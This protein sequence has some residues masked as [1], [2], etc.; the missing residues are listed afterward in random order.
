MTIDALSLKPN[1]LRFFTYNNGNKNIN[2]FVIKIDND[3]ISFL[4]ACSS[5]KSRLGYTFGNGQF[6]CKECGVEYSVSEI[7]NGIGTCH[8]ISIPGKLMD[9]KYYIPVMELQKLA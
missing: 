9:G 1:V 6:T 8:P 2:F 7:K 5:C 4:D 3:V